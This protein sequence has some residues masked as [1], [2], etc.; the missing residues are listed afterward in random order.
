ML[1]SYFADSC[2]FAG[3]DKFEPELKQNFEAYSLQKRKKDI[4]WVLLLF[5]WKPG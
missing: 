2:R 5:L 3:S 4:I 1:A